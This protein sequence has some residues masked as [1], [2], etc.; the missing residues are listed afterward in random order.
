MMARLLEYKRAEQEEERAKIAAEKL[1]I[2]WGSQ[3]RSYVNHPYRMVKDHRTSHET[4]QFDAVLEGQL[5]PFM[6]AYLLASSK[7]E[8]TTA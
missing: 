8:L 2:E 5:D 4:S 3:I 1:K 6:E 7:G